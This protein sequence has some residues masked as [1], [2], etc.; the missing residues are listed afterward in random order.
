[1][2]SR[3]SPATAFAVAAAGT[4]IYSTMDAVMKELSIASG[5]Y[6]AVLW[7]SVAGCALAGTIFVVRGGRWPERAALR[8]H[9]AR[10]LSAGISVLLFFWGLARV[11]MAKSVALTF[12]APLIAIF[13]ASALL[14]ERVR[15]AAILGALIA[16]TGVMVIAVGEISSATPA[17]SMLGTC[18][19]VAASFLYAWSLVLLRRQAQAADPLEVTLFSSLTIGAALLIGAPIFSSIPQANQL[20]AILG[21]AVLATAAGLLLAWAYRHAEAQLLAPVEY[22]AFIWASLLGFVVFDE[23]VSGYTLAGAV[24]IIV[25][26]IAALHRASRPAG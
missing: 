21:A 15:P 16:T 23:R 6:S 10:G 22:S 26:S 18:A 4:A 19:I 12:L 5:A 3:V 13:L 1:M 11:P 17:D 9:I 7:R 8:L 25:G 14:G 24:L 20:P 2:S